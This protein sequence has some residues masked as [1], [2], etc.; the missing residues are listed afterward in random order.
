MKKGIYAGSFD[1]PTNGHL[2]MIAQGVKLFDMLIVA[3][4]TNPDKKYAFSLEERVEML[5]DI[6]NRYP[7]ITLDTFENQ[8]LVNYAKSVG[9]DIIL[10]GL[11]SEGDYEYE[12]IMRYINSD[13]NPNILTVF[14]IPPREIAGISSSFVK[15]LVG[16][17]GWEAAVKKYVPKPVYTKF[18]TKFRNKIANTRF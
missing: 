16:P 11:R 2:W 6:I 18:L 8:F 5:N 14:L 10:R 15:G 9:S 3:I 7:N 13:L 12:R 17:E 4:G 1:P